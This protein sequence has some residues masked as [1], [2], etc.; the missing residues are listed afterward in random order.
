[1]QNPKTPL[2]PTSSPAIIQRVRRNPTFTPKLKARVIQIL[3]VIDA[4]KTVGIK[5]VKIVVS[6]IYCDFS[7]ETNF[8]AFFSD[9]LYSN[10]IPFGLYRISL[11]VEFL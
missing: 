5:I 2:T 10:W 9:K 8:C 11:I 7:K 4:T 6:N 1:M 3:G